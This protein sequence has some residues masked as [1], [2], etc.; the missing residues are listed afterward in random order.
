[1]LSAQILDREGQIERDVNLGQ[2]SN[3]T[4]NGW[5]VI[6]IAEMS[7]VITKANKNLPKLNSENMEQRRRKL[8]PCVWLRAGTRPERRKP[9]IT[10]EILT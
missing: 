2:S 1:M 4:P 8:V 5:R 6:R 3:F 7:F 10:K 9:D